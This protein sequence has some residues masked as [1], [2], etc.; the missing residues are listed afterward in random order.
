MNIFAKHAPLTLTMSRS[1]LQL[2]CLSLVAMGIAYSIYHAL[3]HYGSLGIIWHTYEHG[4]KLSK[5]LQ[6]AQNTVTALTIAALW[7][8]VWLAEK[9]KTRD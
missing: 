4:Y 6:T 3:I 9:G 2:V 5:V 7:G 1:R 8:A